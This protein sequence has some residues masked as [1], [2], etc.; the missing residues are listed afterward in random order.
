MEDAFYIAKL[1]YFSLTG[2]IF[3][4][5]LIMESPFN[6]D[7]DMDENLTHLFFYILNII[8]SAY[9]F[10][11]C[12]QNPGCVKLPE[13]DVT[14]LEKRNLSSKYKP[15]FDLGSH[16][17]QKIENAKHSFKTNSFESN[18]DIKEVFELHELKEDVHLEFSNKHEKS[19]K[20][21]DSESYDSFVQDDFS[22]FSMPPKHYCNTCQIE[23]EYR[24]RHCH[25][26]EKCIYKYDHHCFWIGNI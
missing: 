10:L 3:L 21:S 20:K 17:I 8:I 16:N 2:I 15:P 11:T 13:S 4:V 23:Q 12:G 6:H 9:Y 1:V 26:C 24:T 7:D 19:A 25:K 14:S 5:L 22:V 18:E